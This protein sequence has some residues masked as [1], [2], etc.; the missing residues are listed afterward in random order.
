MDVSHDYML[1]KL[2]KIQVEE[3][4]CGSWAS[5]SEEIANPC[6]DGQND[7][8]IKSV[9]DGEQRP[10]FL[11]EHHV[12]DLIDGADPRHDHASLDGHRHVG[13]THVFTEM[14]KS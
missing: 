1:M 11:A 7:C 12:A 2:M 4:V 10:W 9:I 13:D 8:R 6:A 3:I 5:F 14:C